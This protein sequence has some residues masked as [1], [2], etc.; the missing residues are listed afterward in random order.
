MNKRNG[1]FMF[2]KYQLHDKILHVIYE[3]QV[4]ELFL[5]SN[6]E[7]FILLIKHPK[8][9]KFVKLKKFE[10][11]ENICIRKSFLQ[12]TVIVDGSSTPIHQEVRDGIV[13]RTNAY[14]DTGHMIWFKKK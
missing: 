5:L 9:L 14:P 8:Y 4:F 3:Y 10:R 1:L 12:S 11:R 13:S 6:I 7:L 2:K